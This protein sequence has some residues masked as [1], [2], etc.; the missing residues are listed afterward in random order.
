MHK[1]V[2]D[3]WFERN[4]TD[5]VTACVREGVPIEDE[6][7]YEQHLADELIRKNSLDSSV[8]IDSSKIENYDF[9]IQSEKFSESPYSPLVRIAL[10]RFSKDVS[11]KGLRRRAHEINEAG[12]SVHYHLEPYSN[13]NRDELW[14]YLT[15]E[16]H[17][18]VEDLASQNC[19]DVL[20]E[21]RNR[22]AKLKEQERDLR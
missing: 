13:L 16:V 14:I 12:K 11:D 10:V 7:L 8:S 5:Y 18:A 4:P 9:R 15:E 2:K 6:Y 20:I 19:P 1:S 17:R 22:N 21:V 3:A